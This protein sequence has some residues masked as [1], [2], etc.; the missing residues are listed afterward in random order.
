MSDERINVNNLVRL[1]LIAILL[2]LGI[3]SQDLIIL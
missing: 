2:I 1:V 3:N